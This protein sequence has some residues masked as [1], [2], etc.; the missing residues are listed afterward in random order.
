MQQCLHLDKHLLQ[1]KNTQ[2]LCGTKNN[3][4]MAQLEQMIDNKK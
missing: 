1:Q 3:C 2:K 4:A